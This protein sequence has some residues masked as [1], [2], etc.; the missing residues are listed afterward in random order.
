MGFRLDTGG[1]GGGGGGN[2]LTIATRTDNSELAVFAT[3]AALETYTATPDGATDA[4]RINVNNINDAVEAFVVGTITD[5]AFVGTPTAYVRVNNAWVV[6]LAPLTG[7]PGA[8]GQD[9]TA[10]EFESVAA[11]DAFFTM[12]PELL[13]N[14]LPVVVNLGDNMVS[15]N[16]WNGVNSPSDFTTDDARW[17]TA[18]T[19]VSNNS[20]FVGSTRISNSVQGV[21]VIDARGDR[22]I[23]IGA[24]YD[25]TG[26]QD[27]ITFALGIEET[28]N[29]NLV[30]DTTI[31]APITIQYDTFGDNFTTDF[32]I[33]PATAGQ[34]RA[35]FFI[36]SDD[37][38][39]LIFDE[40]RDVTQQEADAGAFISFGI[41]NPYILDQNLGLFARFTGVD[42]LGGV[43][44]DPDSQFNGQTLI[45]FRST[46]QPFTRK[47]MALAE[48]LVDSLDADVSGD[49]LTVTLGRGQQP[50]LTAT[51]TLPADGTTPPPAPIPRF[52]RFEFQSQPTSV[53]AG[54]TISGLKTF[55]ISID[56][57]D[58]LTGHLTITQDGTTLTENTLLPSVRSAGVPITS[59]ELTNPGDTTTFTIS[60]TITDGGTIMSHITIRAAQPHELAYWGIRTANDFAAVDLDDLNNVDVT[61]NNEFTVSGDVDQNEWIGILVPS[62][63]DVASITLFNLPALDSFTRDA[64]AR[65]IGGVQYISYVKQSLAQFTTEINAQVRV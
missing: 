47:P 33:I 6:S 53:S 29:V 16:V 61:V 43:V 8:D 12:R 52:T 56:R 3:F 37:T 30:N 14:G 51:V 27:P 26:S 18:S 31:N 36:G 59:V 57:I 7:L 60:A 64:A 21:S 9:G 34:L 63:H 23:A 17:R 49:Q 1:P 38:G 42:L 4:T 55:L 10:L 19:M 25:N 40:T 65:T 15:T 54:T 13:R 46:V 58:L 5:N 28:L 41:G 50:D 45:S 35:E 22:F 20:L 48:D 32:E 11:R 44:D 62:T 2:N 39:T 24:G